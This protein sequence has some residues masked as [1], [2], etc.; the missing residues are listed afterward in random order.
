MNRVSQWSGEAI[1]YTNLACGERGAVVLWNSTILDR[2]KIAA[3]VLRSMLY[4][5]AAANSCMY[6]QLSAAFARCHKAP[7][8]PA[9]PVLC[10]D[11][12]GVGCTLDTLCY[13]PRDRDLLMRMLHV[14][15]SLGQSRQFSNQ[16]WLASQPRIQQ[17]NSKSETVL[18]HIV[19]I[20]G[21]LAAAPHLTG[22][23][24]RSNTAHNYTGQ[25]LPP[26]YH[27]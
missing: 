14:R 17:R 12:D 21:V 20:L 16:E 27:T 13:S 9:S 10:L 18:T 4:S 24:G 8:G 6:I 19:T 26:R 25:P 7:C 22:E 15:S 3:S 1:I 5:S 23:D 2:C 11:Q